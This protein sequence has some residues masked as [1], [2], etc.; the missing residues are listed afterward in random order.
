MTFFHKL[1]SGV[2]ILRA[3]TVWKYIQCYILI[4]NINKV[5]TSD[6]GSKKSDP[7]RSDRKMKEF[8]CYPIR[9]EPI[10]TNPIRSGLSDEF[11]RSM[12][13]TIPITPKSFAFIK[14]FFY[15]SFRELVS[16]FLR[17]YVSMF[18]RGGFLRKKSLYMKYSFSIHTSVAFS[19][20]ARKKS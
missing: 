11:I 6:I 5:S 1:L 8:G 20:L 3:A 13:S 14:V 15:V 16:A 19:I 2:L 18:L 7:I 10:R 17:F 12:Y 9:S 4:P